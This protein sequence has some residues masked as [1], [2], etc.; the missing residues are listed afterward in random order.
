MV[1]LHTIID[2]LREC[3]AIKFQDLDEFFEFLIKPWQGGTGQR[4]P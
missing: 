3:Y 1:C 2:R 4:R